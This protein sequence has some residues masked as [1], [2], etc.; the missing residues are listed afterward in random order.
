MK[1]G[2]NDPLIDIDG[3]QRKR[4]DAEGV[5]EDS[6]GQRLI[7]IRIAFFPVAPEKEMSG[8]DAVIKRAGLERMPLQAG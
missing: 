5:L 7:E 2:V 3:K 8:Q 4:Y 1:E 6:E